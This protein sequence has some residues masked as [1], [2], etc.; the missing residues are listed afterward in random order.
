M[1]EAFS[2]VVS[3]EQVLLGFPRITH[4]R[5][6]EYDS[7][8][9]GIAS[10]STRNNLPFRHHIILK[11]KLGQ[12]QLGNGAV[13]MPKFALRWPGIKT[14]AKPHFEDLK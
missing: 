9:G 7:C 8:G 5:I 14:N 10:T 1:R 6:Q 11:F 2:H 4:L 12:L 13:T 3:T